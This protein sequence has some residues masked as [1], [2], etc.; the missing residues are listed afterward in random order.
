MRADKQDKRMSIETLPIEM[1]YI[2]YDYYKSSKIYLICFHQG[3]LRVNKLFVIGEMRVIDEAISPDKRFYFMSAVSNGTFW[4]ELGNPLLVQL[5]A[6]ETDA[7][8][9]PNSRYLL[10][11][12][13]FGGGLVLFDLYRGTKRLLVK[14]RDPTA[15]TYQLW[16][17]WYPDSRSIW[18]AVPSPSVNPKYK[19]PF[20][21]IDLTTWRRRRLSP[22]E[23]RQILSGW[24]FLDPRFRYLPGRSRSEY[25]Y[26]YSVD[27]QWRVKVG[28]YVFEDERHR[29]LPFEQQV[30]HQNV[31]LERR[32]GRSK[33]LLK[34]GAHAWWLEPHDI[35]RDGRWVLLLGNRVSD[36]SRWDAIVIDTASNRHWIA[37]SPHEVP[38]PE[39]ERSDWGILY[40]WFGKQ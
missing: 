7:R 9:S 1:I 8:F 30:K 27:R 16:F 13:H 10:G 37:F 3:K 24:D 26:A 28:P 36:R 2:R 6:R 38:I 15:L 4:G 11:S 25:R 33:V 21:R 39:G 20:F 23:K 5:D 18:Y 34:A 12:Y 14:P 29:L 40:L 31:V 17:G 22:Q 35:T 19:E 32:D